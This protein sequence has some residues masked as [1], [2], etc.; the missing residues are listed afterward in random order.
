MKRNTTL[1][2]YFNVLKYEIFTYSYFTFNNLS[3]KCTQLLKLYTFLYLTQT[4]STQK[5][6]LGPSLS[7]SHCRQPPQIVDPNDGSCFL[8]NRTWLLCTL[9]TSL[10][11]IVGLRFWA[12]L[13]SCNPPLSTFKTAMENNRLRACL[14]FVCVL[15]LFSSFRSS[16]SSSPN[17]L[18]G[19]RMGPFFGSQKD[20]LFRAI[21]G[22]GA[23]AGQRKYESNQ[24]YSDTRFNSSWIKG[25]PCK[26]GR[27]GE[28]RDDI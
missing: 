21:F 14:P 6:I 8:P 9:S 22:D 7:T 18:F 16:F 10:L 27:T 15:L 4:N 12:T 24:A 5:H 19:G 17:A 3:Y 25:K 2:S 20:C 26:T 1:W 28:K 23:G 13:G 11:P